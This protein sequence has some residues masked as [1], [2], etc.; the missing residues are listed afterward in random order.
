MDSVA[1]KAAAARDAGMI[2]AEFAEIISGS[3]YTDALYAAICQVARRQAEVHVDAVL[4]LVKI[5]PAHPNAAGM[6]WVRAIR[7]GVIQRTGNV[8]HCKADK[9]KNMHAYPVY[10]SLVFRGVEK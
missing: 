3:Q 6:V 9:A 7:D 10:R 8:R 5:K 1:F 4:P 2:E